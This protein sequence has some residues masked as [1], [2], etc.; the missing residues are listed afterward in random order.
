MVAK[1]S[2]PLDL[3][4]VLEALMVRPMQILGVFGTA[5]T[6][7]DKSTNSLIYQGSI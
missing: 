3:S 2:K 4:G 5:E 1:K 7:I 6:S